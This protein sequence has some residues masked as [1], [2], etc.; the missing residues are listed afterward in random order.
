MAQDNMLLLLGR[1]GYQLLVGAGN[2]MQHLFL[3]AFRLNW[4]WQFYKSGAGKL[5][6]HS[7]IVDFF[8]SLG[9]PLPDLNA[10]MV[11]GVESVGGLLLLAGLASRP[12][13]LVLTV[14]MTVAYLSVEDDRKSVL[15]FFKDQDSF[16]QADPFFFLL[17]ALMVFCFGPGKIS[18]DYLLGRFVFNKGV[19]EAQPKE[20]E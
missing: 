12:V 7:D 5:K 20:T 1:K 6:N 17:T 14:N 10:W 8:T 3:L 9:I 2:L 18:I 11:G 16:L 15:N 13:G 19:D 4:G